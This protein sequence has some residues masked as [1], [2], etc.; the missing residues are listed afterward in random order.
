MSPHRKDVPAAEE[1]QA[2]SFGRSVSIQQ[3]VD[4]TQEDPSSPLS[5]SPFFTDKENIE[6]LEWSRQQDNLP[7]ESNGRLH[8][9]HELD[10]GQPSSPVAP[11]RRR[12]SQVGSYDD[13][14]SIFDGPSAGAVPSSVSR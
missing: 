12:D 5:H 7:E 8:E 3:D 9:D 11:R 14:G 13:F 1:Y 6:A 4:L 10:D 2:P